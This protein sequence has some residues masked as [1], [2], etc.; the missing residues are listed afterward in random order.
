MECLHFSCTVPGL[1]DQLTLGLRLR[2]FVWIQRARGK[3]DQRLPN[4]KPEVANQAD[5]PIGKSRHDDHC[6]GVANN[7]PALRLAA[8]S[9]EGIADNSEA[10]GGEQK[11][12]RHDEFL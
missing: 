7:F 10:F 6:A 1:L 3:L 2:R 4:R 8:A 11:F 12:F 9:D 5:A